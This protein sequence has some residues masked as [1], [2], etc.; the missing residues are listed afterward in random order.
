MPDLCTI[1]TRH[2]DRSTVVRLIG[3]IDA[4]NATLIDSELRAIAKAGGNVLL[5]DLNA[6]DYVDSAGIATL[7]RTTND[8]QC[9]IV[10]SR[11]AIVYQ[12]LN[13]VGFNQGHELHGSVSEALD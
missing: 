4:S 2:T 11:D 1:E 10:I 12:A 6:L 5:V 9:R 13:V 8:L 3:E 7:E